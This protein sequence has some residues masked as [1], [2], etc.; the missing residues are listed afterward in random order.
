MCVR[1]RCTFRCDEHHTLA[2]YICLL[3]TSYARPCVSQISNR[4][5]PWT[6]ML[7]G[8]FR[9]S[10]VSLLL[11]L[12]PRST[13]Y[14]LSCG[15]VECRQGHT[16]YLSIAR[17]YGGRAVDSSAPQQASH[18]IGAHCLWP[19]NLAAVAFFLRPLHL[20]HTAWQR[21]PAEVRRAFDDNCCYYCTPHTRT[22]RLTNV[23]RAL[24]LLGLSTRLTW[25]HYRQKGKQINSPSSR[26]K[27]ER[28][29]ALCL[30]THQFVWHNVYAECVYT[31][32]N[33]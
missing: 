4:R 26:Q 8:H 1:A 7:N 15:V 21:T 28:K 19:L 23:S 9:L 17:P 13:G 30:C 14:V 10:A 27:N 31:P 12:F 32:E 20:I 33:Q 16:W 11:A 2:V 18:S 5:C 22:H 29:Y 6:E 3:C 24:F 25:P